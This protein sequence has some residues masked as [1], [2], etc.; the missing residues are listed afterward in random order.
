[1]NSFPTEPVEVMETRHAHF[2][3]GLLALLQDSKTDDQF[4]A[5]LAKVDEQALYFSPS[6]GSE[7]ER[8][9]VPVDFHPHQPYFLIAW[10]D[11]LNFNSYVLTPFLYRPEIKLLADVQSATLTF[12]RFSVATKNEATALFVTLCSFNQFDYNWHRESRWRNCGCFQPFRLLHDTRSLTFEAYTVSGSHNLFSLLLFLGG[13][14]DHSNFF[15]DSR[16]LED[17]P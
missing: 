9:A 13:L 4:E 6:S 1:M 11:L 2:P 12:P 10:Q 17:T 8:V 3:I 14:I 16:D 7:Q 15:P 5:R